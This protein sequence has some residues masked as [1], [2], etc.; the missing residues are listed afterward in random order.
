MFLTQIGNSFWSIHM[1]QWVRAEKIIPC[2]ILFFFFFFKWLFQKQAYK[3]LAFSSEMTTV[4]TFCNKFVCLPTERSVTM[5]SSLNN[6]VLFWKDQQQPP[7]HC[8]EMQTQL[9]SSLSLQLIRDV[10]LCLLPPE[11]KYTL[12]GFSQSLLEFQF[13]FMESQSLLCTY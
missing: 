12:K 7:P 4:S 10:C 13:C 8:I 2:A 3:I 5:H 6:D 9:S 11:P 1:L